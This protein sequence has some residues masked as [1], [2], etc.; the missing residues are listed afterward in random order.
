MISPER[1]QIDFYNINLLLSDERDLKLNEKRETNK[2]EQIKECTFHPKISFHRSMIN[3]K[4]QYRDFTKNMK[5]KQEGDCLN[6]SLKINKLSTNKKKSFIIK[7]K[8]TQHSKTN[9]PTPFSKTAS[10]LASDLL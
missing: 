1:N 8:E 2:L 10:T 3:R 4:D 7:Q 9:C 6:S 5:Y